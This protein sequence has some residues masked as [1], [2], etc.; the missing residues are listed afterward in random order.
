MIQSDNTANSGT[1]FSGL[2]DSMPPFLA[3]PDDNRHAQIRIRIRIPKDYSQ[4]PV[5]SYVTSE[6]GV[7]VNILAALL[8]ADARTDG[9]FD[10]E[11][12]G[13]IQ[14]IQHAL[15]YLHELNLEIW[16]DTDA[17]TDGW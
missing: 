13:S 7:T 15:M 6:Y 11:L 8:G 5:I 1:R 16:Y 2:S 10:L 14:Q 17:Q 9:W 4:E 12:K 3:A